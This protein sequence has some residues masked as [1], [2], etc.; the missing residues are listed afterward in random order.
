M[1]VTSQDKR[2]REIG[3]SQEK[4]PGWLNPL[5]ILLIINIKC[6]TEREKESTIKQLANLEII[7]QLLNK[8]MTQTYKTNILSSIKVWLGLL[9]V[10]CCCDKLMQKPSFQLQLSLTCQTQAFAGSQGQTELM[11]SLSAPLTMIGQ[12]C[13]P[14]WSYRTE[15]Q[16]TKGSISQSNRPPTNPEEASKPDLT[17]CS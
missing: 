16:S 14:S 3:S 12:T 13:G 1:Q 4:T 15:V 7:S 6:S 5:S 2:T 11:L 9:T 17:F 8:G 10:H